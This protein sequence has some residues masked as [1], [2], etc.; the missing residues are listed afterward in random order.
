MMEMEMEMVLVVWCSGY[1]NS[2]A[3]AL[4]IPT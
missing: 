1:A 2:V 3:A 4:S